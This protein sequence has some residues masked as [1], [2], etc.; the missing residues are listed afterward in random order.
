MP[1]LA[2]S[3]ALA[4]LAL[5]ATPATAQSPDGLDWLE[6]KWEGQMGGAIEET[7]SD[8]RAGSRIGMFRWTRG[9]RVIVYEFMQVATDSTGSSFRFKHFGGAMKGWEEK[10]EVIILPHA[11]NINGAIRFAGVHRGKQMALTYQPTGPD[12]MRVTLESEQDDGQMQRLEFEYQ[13]V[14]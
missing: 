3:A 14:K 12:A 11:G 8:V 7:W 10:D 9:D 5:L 1:R 6:G 13:R 2:A 4:A